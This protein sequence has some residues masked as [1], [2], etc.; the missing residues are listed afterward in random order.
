MYRG[1]PREEGGAREPFFSVIVPFRDE[2]ECLE[3]TLPRIVAAVASYPRAE[4]ILVDN[5]SQDGSHDW[6]RRN[7]GGS[8]TLLELADAS[9]GAVRNHGARHAAG[10]VLCFIDADC[11]VEPDHLHNARRARE[12][13]SAAVVGARYRLPS[14]AGWVETTWHRLHRTDREGYVPFLSAGNL[15]VDAEAFEEVGGFDERLVTGEDAELCSRLRA[16]GHR[17]YQDPAITAVHLGN[18]KTVRGFFQKQRWYALGMFGTVRGFSFDKPVAATLG[19]LLLVG[20][21]VAAIAA[22]SLGLGFELLV[23]TAALL[24]MP[25]VAV[26]YRW[27]QTGRVSR[28]LRSLLLYEIFF[29]ARI[30][31]AVLLVTGLESGW[32]PERE[33]SEPGAWKAYELKKR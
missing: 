31:A 32:R 15:I 8:L 29:A 5:G 18:A 13:S 27:R 14:D 10:D 33:A 2:R 11:L 28:P 30:T 9:I 16:R 6:V 20:G 26:G 3:R 7:Y 24:L 1:R 12:T 4:L 21:A 23:L 19:H 25:A 17:I 22:T